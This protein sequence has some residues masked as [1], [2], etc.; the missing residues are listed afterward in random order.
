MK[1]FHGVN[2]AR[3]ERMQPFVGVVK[4]HKLA[5]CEFAHVLMNVPLSMYL[6]A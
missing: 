4:V 2:F 1:P 3:V 5:E 6:A